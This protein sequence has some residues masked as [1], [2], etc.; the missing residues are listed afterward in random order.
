MYEVRSNILK[1][2]NQPRLSQN[3]KY[4]E[5]WEIVKK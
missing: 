1:Q 2:S 3:R 5:L 4:K